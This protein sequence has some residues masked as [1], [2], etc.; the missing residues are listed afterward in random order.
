[1]SATEYSEDNLKTR[2]PK[3]LVVDDDEL[4]LE[5]VSIHLRNSGYR[6]YAA[7]DGRE[8]LDM[9][10]D[11]RDMEV[12]ILDR[13]LPNMDGMEF[14]KILKEDE[15]LFDI[16]VI[17]QTAA[18]TSKEVAEGVEA[19]VFY[20]LPK[21]YDMGYM[22]SVVGNALRDYHG[23]RKIQEEVHKQWH[24]LGL[25]EKASF[26]F[27][28][29]EEAA[30]LCYLVSNR[31]PAPEKIVYALHELLYNAIEHGNLGIT[32]EEKKSLLLNG[33]W[34]A[35]I[36]RRLAA[37]EY[38]NRFATLEFE[39]TEHAYI[40]TI[41][42]QGQGFDWKKY[43]HLSSKRVTDPNGRGIVQAARVFSSMEYQRSGNKVVATFLHNTPKTIKL[44]TMPQLTYSKGAYRVFGLPKNTQTSSGGATL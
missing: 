35:E 15:R 16:P 20:Y 42:D 23:H 17:M 32:Y 9:L 33:G 31:Y 18:A 13:M 6:V 5:L 2:L 40:V 12:I 3:V 29:L 1:M 30:N 41:T 39:A 22:L 34:Q 36:T 37:P 38:R 28:T 43:T 10:L 8:G 4:N 11:H 25:L 26:K 44:K 19:G 21:P 24:A 14:L 27:R 7:A